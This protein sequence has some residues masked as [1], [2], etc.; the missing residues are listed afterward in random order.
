[1]ETELLNQ[2]G[3]ANG[4]VFLEHRPTERVVVKSYERKNWLIR[5]LGRFL[6]A[7]ERR[8]Y[9][10]L[11]GIKGIPE[12]RPDANPLRLSLVYVDSEQISSE[13]LALEGENII[14]HLRRVVADMHAR[15]IYHLDL[16]NRGNVLVDPHGYC[17]LIDFASSLYLPPSSLRRRLL[18]PLARRFDAYGLSKWEQRAG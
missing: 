18:A 16:R 14:A 9:H 8:A 13:R 3:W 7:R 12:L 11:Q 10:R 4:A 5:L 15:G 2:G 1:M 17:Y 6:L